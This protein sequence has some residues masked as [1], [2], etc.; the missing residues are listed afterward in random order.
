GLKE[1]VWVELTP[2]S[3]KPAPV[4]RCGHVA[5]PSHDGSNLIVIGGYHE[6]GLLGD[7]WS[8][9]LETCTWST[10]NIPGQAPP[11][12]AFFRGCAGPPPGKKSGESYNKEGI[13]AYVFGGCDE[14]EFSNDLWCLDLEDRVW[15]ITHQGGNDPAVPVPRG[16]HG[17][18][19]MNS[20]LVVH[21]GEIAAGDLLGDFWTFDTSSLT[22]SKR[23]LNPT[24][25]GPCPRSSHCLT[26]VASST[27]MGEGT[28]AI[29]G[30]MGN[31]GG[32]MESDPVP[33]NDLWVCTNATRSGTGVGLG[34]RSWNWS[35]VLLEGI[36][37]SPR[38]L[39]ALVAAMPSD[40]SDVEEA[41]SGDDQIITEADLFVFGGY[42]LVELPPPDETR[43]SLQSNTDII[44]DGGRIITAYLDDLWTLDL[45]RCH[46]GLD[47]VDS[48]R[49]GEEGVEDSRGRFRGWVDEAGMGFEGESPVEGR[50]GHSLV[51]CGRGRQLILFGG[52]VG[53]GFDSRV[54]SADLPLSRG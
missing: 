33:L 22:W 2:L 47:V 24:G 40:L 27:S 20:N 26:F 15:S 34:E 37:P 43:D 17:M 23:L 52:F 11:L 36:G 32:N 39:A 10:I 46:S 49:V 3:N 18:C 48:G 51:V 19:A 16:N 53:D 30:G 12:R 38:S 25:P 1:T 31:L 5:V 29:F 41:H 21:G 9:D 4:G 50:N 7:V 42:G 14:D 28:L 6:E 13:F 45:G 54:Y 35:L 8:F 44:E